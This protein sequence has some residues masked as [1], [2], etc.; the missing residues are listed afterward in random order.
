[1]PYLPFILVATI[2]VVLITAAILV[3]F[4]GLLQQLTRS[5]GLLCAEEAKGT[6][7]HFASSQIGRVALD[8]EQFLTE[9]L[10]ILPD[11][12]KIIYFCPPPSW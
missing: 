10:Y 3:R 9:S 5:V 1:M 4:L 6:C 7:H 8:C 12:S 11:R 2:L